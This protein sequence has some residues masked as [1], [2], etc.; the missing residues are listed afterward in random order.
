[1]TSSKLSE[2]HS[3]INSAWEK[4]EGMFEKVAD[5]KF[6]VACLDARNAPNS[7]DFL[8]RRDK[9]VSDLISIKRSLVSIEDE[10][11]AIARSTKMVD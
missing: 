7:D 2:L 5:A 4:V 11:K 8:E 1:M 6:T 3:D 10:F 9:I